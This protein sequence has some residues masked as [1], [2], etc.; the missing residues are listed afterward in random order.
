MLFLLR[1]DPKNR[2]LPLSFNGMEV[3]ATLRAELDRECTDVRVSSDRVGQFLFSISRTGAMHLY[4]LDRDSARDL[5]IT[6][7]AGDAPYI[8][9]ARMMHLSPLLPPP[10]RREGQL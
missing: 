8:H 4:S 10:N 5:G 9:V 7:S 2:A 6:L 1:E 3:N